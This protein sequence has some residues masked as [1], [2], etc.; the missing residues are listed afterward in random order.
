MDNFTNDII[1]FT[2]PF[3]NIYTIYSKSGCPNCKKVK[4]LLEENNIK[5]IIVDCDEYLINYKTDFLQF[6]KNLISKEWKTFPIVF[7]NTYFIGGF[8]DTDNYLE[9]SLKTLL[10]FNEDF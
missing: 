7:D 9:K 4:T 10:D 5:F 3:E 6:I 8:S 1:E 2:K